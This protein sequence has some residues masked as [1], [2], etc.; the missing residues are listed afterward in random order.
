MFSSKN[1]RN[2]IRGDKEKKLEMVSNKFVLYQVP[3]LKGNTSECSEARVLGTIPVMTYS[4]REMIGKRK[5]A[6]FRQWCWLPWR[7]EI[8]SGVVSKIKSPLCCGT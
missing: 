8:H 6:A 5:Q 3:F 2:N 4:K 1:T 7:P